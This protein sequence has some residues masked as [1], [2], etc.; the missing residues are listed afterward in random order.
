M[1]V[2]NAPNN[3]HKTEAAKPT[4]VTLNGHVTLV[5]AL[6]VAAYGRLLIL[7]VQNRWQPP[8]P[9]SAPAG[10]HVAV[11]ALI[12]TGATATGASGTLLRDVLVGVIGHQQRSDDADNSA[13]GNIARNHVARSGHGPGPG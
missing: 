5:R 8:N 6:I 1:L 2:R 7:L 12:D 11:Q 4:L 3:G 13:G 10:G 9:A